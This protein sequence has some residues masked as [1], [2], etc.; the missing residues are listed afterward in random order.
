MTN[1][2]IDINP[3]NSLAG[4][5]LMVFIFVA[6]YFIAKSIFTLLSWLAPVLLIATAIMNPKVLTSYGKWIINLLKKN[7]LF[8][9][10]AII[11]TV[12]GFPVVSGF[13]FAKAMLYRKA[14]QMKKE[15][16]SQ[17]H[18]ELI[19]Y[20]EIEE[21]DPIVPLELPPI[22]KSKPSVRQQPKQKPRPNNEYEQFFDE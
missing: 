4:I 19:E 2:K 12:I 13:L 5:L 9:I 21:D 8:G 10:G 22:K 11:M 7:P 3:G 1:R 6:L 14:D 18:G 15:Y 17:T 20:E 16:E